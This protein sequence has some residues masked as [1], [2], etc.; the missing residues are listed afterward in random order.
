MTVSDPILELGSN[1]QNTGDIGLVMS[2]HGTNKSNVA[3]FFDES[4]D[5]LKLGYTLNGANDSTLELD[6]NALAV[7]IQGDIYMGS[8]LVALNEDI[9]SVSDILNTSSVGVSATAGLNA[10]VTIANKVSGSGIDMSF[11]LP[12]GDTGATGAAATISSVSTTTGAAGTDASVTLGGSSTNRT[13]AFTIPRGNTGATGAT[14]AKGDTGNTGPQGPTGATGAA[15]TISSVSTT[16]GTA[17]TNASVTLGGSST[18]RTLAFTIP[19]GNTGATGATGATGPTGAKGDTGN[20][21][22]QGPQ[23]NTG[24]QGPQGGTDLASNMIFNNMGISHGSAYTDF[25]AIPDA[26]SYYI[27]GTTNGPNVN[28]ANQYYGMTLGLGSEYGPVKNQTGK[29]GSQIYWGR[30]VT[31]PYI[32]IRYLENGSWG[33]WRK[34]AAGYADSAAT[35]T[36]ATNQ[37][38]GTVSATTG[39]FSGAV[40]TGALTV[41]G[42]IDFTPIYGG[43][44][45]TNKSGMIIFNKPAG[46]SIDTSANIDSIYYD[47]NQNAYHFTQDAGKYAT[48]NAKLVFGSATVS[49]TVTASAFSGNASTATT[50]ATARAINGVDFDG[51]AAITITANTPQTLTRGNYLT[52]SNFNGGTATTWAVDA[53]EAATASKIV[54]RNSS[55]D[56]YMRYGH[57][58]YLNMSHSAAT[59]SGD[60]VFYSSTDNYIRKNNSTGFRASLNVP[61]RTG[62][63]ASGTWGISIS[64]NAATATKLATARAINGVNFDGLAAITVNGTNYNVNNSWFRELGDNAH[65]KQ[66]G[67]SRQMVFRT[68]GTTEYASGIGAYPFVWMYGGDASS[69][70]RMMLNTSGQLWCSNYGWLH[71]KFMARTQVFSDT[72]ANAGF[73]G[74]T[75]DYNA[76][77]SQTTT[78]DR[79]HRALFIDMDSSATGGDTNHEHRM[80]GIYNDVRHSGDSDLVYGMYSYTRSDHTS[81]TT[82]NLRAGDFIA[83]ASGTGTNTNVYGI[84]SFAHKDGGSTGATTT[85]YGIKSEVQVDAGTVTNAYSYHAHIDR[86]GGTLTNGYLYYGSYAGTVGTKWGLYLT[87]ETK[88]YFSGSVGIGQSSPGY[89]LD[90][91]GT[92]HAGNSYFDTVY[93]GGSTSRGLR[94]VSGNYGTVQTTGSGAGDWEGYSIDGRYVFMSKDNNTC[95]IYNDIDNEWMIYCYRNSYTKLYYNGAQKLETTNTGVTITGTVTATT[96]TFS[97]AISQNG[98]ELYAQKRWDIDLTSQSSTNFYPVEFSVPTEQ[99]TTWGDVHPVHFKVYGESLGGGD[100]YNEN[101]LVGYARGGGWSDHPEMYDVHISRFTGG[102]NRFEGLYK[103]TQSYSYGIVIYMRGGYKYSTITDAT[104]VNVYTVA[105]TITNSVFA[106]KNSSGG[107]V[108]GTSSNISRM[109]NIAAST[110]GDQRWMSG[111]VTAPTFSGNATTASYATSASSV[112]GQSSIAKTAH[113]FGANDYHLE[114]ASGYTGDA[115][116]EISLRFHQSNLYWGTLGYNNLGFSFRDGASTTLSAVRVG[117][118]Y[119]SGT[120]ESDGRIYADNG[121]H[122]RTDWLRV[123]GNNGIYFESYGGGWRMTD[124]T[125]VRVYNDKTIY[126]GGHIL[127][128]GNVTAYSDIRHKKDLI[129]LNNALEKVEKLNGYTY[130]SKRDDKRYTGLVAQ[131]VLEV[132]PEAVNEE[133]GGYSLAYGNMAGLFVEAIKDMKSKLDDALARLSAL[134]NTLS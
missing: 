93:I 98:K 57:S 69:N 1:N 97:G 125:Y 112:T 47:D 3:I 10:G 5:V 74:Q 114:L 68:D 90:V 61:T 56:I 24:P 78:A 88:N 121:C 100:P 115:S 133:D 120:I 4:A 132:L 106:I 34:V 35:A 31:N 8:K 129:K 41:D 11:T 117:S 49:G 66:Y 87:G 118:L 9:P 64:G 99:E 82:T 37:S 52:G 59:R 39:T 81:G 48:G 55:G 86:N 127:A 105:T 130:T 108:S 67:N 54:A 50:L 26:G 101:T 7:N 110:Q 36:T 134:E 28:S 77:G 113:T 85:M 20:T 116:T 53:T 89:K 15:A 51:S 79:V 12:K 23:G 94:S 131:E 73:N 102:E 95:G 13:L 2:R 18:N 25:N 6:S 32:N 107:D 14:G 63:D 60:T 33:S 104:T 72:D 70:R 17:G 65:F 44:G 43:Q 126:T 96:G 42:N 84:N 75:I 22:P 27:K 29:Y 109:V 119:S 21:G 40:N 123:N 62:G 111:T 122:V 83:Q 38:G 91:N 30:N 71:D 80:Y 124:T 128:G 58:S 76:S 103:G 19:R 46:Q 16:T 45:D 92:L